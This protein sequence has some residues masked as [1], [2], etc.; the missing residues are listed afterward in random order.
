MA[1]AKKKVSLKNKMKAASKAVKKASVKPKLKTKVKTKKSAKK[2]APKTPSPKSSSAAKNK[3][4]TTKKIAG[5]V[6]ATKVHGAGELSSSALQLWLK[7]FLPLGERILVQ[8]VRQQERKSK[9]GLI[10]LEG[11]D[12]SQ[13]VQTA[14]VVKVGSGALMRKGWRRPLDVQVG[15]K[16]LFKS[17][18]PA[19]FTEGDKLFFVITEADVLGVLG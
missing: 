18:G 5:I 10:L 3:A 7:Q 11:A 17:Y 6:K 19:Q 14:E 9:A 12:S 4:S 15:E 2:L 16:V 1:K 8:Q 13:E